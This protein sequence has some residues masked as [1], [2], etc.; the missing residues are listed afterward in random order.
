MF[1]ANLNPFA[2]DNNNEDSIFLDEEVNNKK[3]NKLMFLDAIQK[4]FWNKNRKDS[5]N[6]LNI[7]YK[8]GSSYKV[9][10]RANMTTTFIFDDDKIALAQLGDN[11]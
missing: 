5:D 1:S 11:V 10:T 2:E 9:R 6:T 8:A 4:N 7:K 3:F